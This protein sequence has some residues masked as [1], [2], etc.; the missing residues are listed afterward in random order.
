MNKKVTIE[1]GSQDAYKRLVFE[2]GLKEDSSSITPKWDNMKTTVKESAAERIMLFGT[3]FIH[4]IIP[5]FWITLALLALIIMIG[6][7]VC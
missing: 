6:W 7:A 3:T 4:G 5:A 1:Q 2:L